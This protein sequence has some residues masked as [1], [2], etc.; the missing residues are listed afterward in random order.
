[1]S[2]GAVQLSEGQRGELVVRQQRLLQV[3]AIGHV[4]QTTKTVVVCAQNSD[5]A[6]HVDSRGKLL[7]ASK[8]LHEWLNTLQNA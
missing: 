2:A 5:E 1:M 4:G 7:E 8:Q 3:D 6:T